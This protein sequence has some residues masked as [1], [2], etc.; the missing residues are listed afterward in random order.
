MPL[1]TRRSP[2]VAINNALDNLVWE[3]ARR[4]SSW[5]V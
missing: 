1:L 2:S 4:V 5:A 3:M